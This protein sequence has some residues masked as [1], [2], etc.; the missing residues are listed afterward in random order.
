[1]IYDIA[2]KGNTILVSMYRKTIWVV[3][4]ENIVFKNYTMLMMIITCG[5]YFILMIVVCCLCESPLGFCVG[6]G[7]YSSSS[8][9]SNQHD[10]TPA[11][12]TCGASSGCGGGGGGD[13]GSHR[14]DHG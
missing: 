8:D 11:H 2:I 10:W 5:V 12:Y 14:H 3:N 13:G 9:N 6:S 4:P 7:D 1:M